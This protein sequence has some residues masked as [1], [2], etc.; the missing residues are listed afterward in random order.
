MTT[1][2]FG[3]GLYGRLRQQAGADWQA[4]VNHSFIQQL[5]A[6]TLAESAFRRYLT[7]DYL[8]LIHFARAYALLVYKMRT[9]PEIRA[10]AASL[11][12]IVAELPLHVG[13]CASWG[14]SESQMTSEAEAMETINYTRYVLDIGQSGD[15]LDLLAALLPCVAGYAE[16]GLH[17][18][19]NPATVIDGNPYA[20]WIN[21]YGDMQYLHG[22]QAAIDL[23]ERVGHQRG[24]ESRFDA[25]AEIFTT[26]TR[27]EAA[28]WQMGLNAQ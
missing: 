9:L 6:G 18:L 4:Y 8:F 2:D 1:I 20:P 24:A 16:I 11:Q 10:A 15:A 19:N 3:Q 25:L 23:L 17:L 7:Q 26:A 13:Y 5:G 14:L 21:N 28:F 27:L 12:A 22:V